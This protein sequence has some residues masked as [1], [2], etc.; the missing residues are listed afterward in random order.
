VVDDGRR[1]DLHCASG[2]EH[3]PLRCSEVLGRKWPGTS[4]RSTRHLPSQQPKNGSV[5]SPANEVV[6]FRRSSGFWE[7]AWTVW[8]LSAS[9]P[10]RL[11]G[12]HRYGSS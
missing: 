3:L 8:L 11:C 7:N 5:I 12:S 10:S 4:V 6:D 9:P 2:G 1:P